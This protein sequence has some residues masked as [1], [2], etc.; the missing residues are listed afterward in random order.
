MAELVAAEGAPAIRTEEQH[1]L[2]DYLIGYL[3]PDL[4]SSHFYC[5]PVTPHY[6]SVHQSDAEMKQI[7]I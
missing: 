3:G 6:F 2:I 1:S 4:G 5:I 7:Y